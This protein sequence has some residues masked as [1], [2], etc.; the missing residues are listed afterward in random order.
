M[1]IPV[2]RKTSTGG[3]GAAVA[4]PCHSTE[5][6]KLYIESVCKELGELYISRLTL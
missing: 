5:L 3:S 2:G 6:I 1:H 4:Q